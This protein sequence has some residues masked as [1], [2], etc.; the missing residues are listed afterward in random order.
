[1]GLALTTPLVDVPAGTYVVGT[2]DPWIPD[3]GEAPARTVEL[4]AFRLAPCAVRVHEFAE[5]VEATSYVT[6]AEREG[7]SFV[8]AGEVGDR[9]V[10][11]QAAG[12]PWWLGVRGASWRDGLSSPDEPVVHVSWNDARAYCTWVGARL[13]TEAEWEAAAAGGA[14]GRTF[15]WGNDLT[16]GGRHRCNVWQGS[17]PDRDTGEDGF[18]GRAPVDAFEPNELGLFNMVGNVWEWCADSFG[19]TIPQRSC[20]APTR[21]TA[22]RVQKGGSYLCHASYCARYRIQ[23]RIGNSP[24]SSTGNTGF[25]IAA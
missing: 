19:D 6:E 8:F 16:P 11:G 5:F 14:A 12:T 17:F 18:R 1:V 20:C 15:P 24:D 13:P 4:G 3:D 7:W 25:R 23:A 22:R 10:V 9:P 2:D 21:A